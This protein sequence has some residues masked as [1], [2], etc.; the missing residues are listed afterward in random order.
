LMNQTYNSIEIIIIDDCSDPNEFSKN[1]IEAYIHENKGPNITNFDILVN[2]I[3]IGHS[4]SL[5]SA[6]AKCNSNYIVYVNGDDL[7]P[8]H[9]ISQLMFALIDGNYDIIGGN[10]FQLNRN[11]TFPIQLEKQVSHKILQNNFGVS[12]ELPISMPGTLFKKKFF[13]V[14]L[15]F[16]VSF[17][18]F[19]DALLYLKVIKSN[20]SV[21]IGKINSV[22]YIWRS[23]SGVTNDNSLTSKRNL[24][25]IH[26]HINFI[27]LILQN[28]ILDLEAKQI[29]QF[30]LKLN[31]LK[32]I[33]N[34]SELDNHT[35]KKIILILVNLN[36]IVKRISLS[37]VIRYL[38][39][40]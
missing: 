30:K 32:F 29:K 35:F 21:R 19:E 17:K 39:S 9:S 6:F 24:E 13:T 12:Y 34:F 1:E 3:N 11:E 31:E 16:E 8:S 5:A 25:L 20:P 23:Y 28:Y 27:E 22:S 15:D 33:Q 7:I 2:E 10:L 4:K 36:L 40:K 38:K 37:R 14:V 26:D 18:Y